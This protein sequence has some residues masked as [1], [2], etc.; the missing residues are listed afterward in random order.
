MSYLGIS[1]MDRVEGL[2]NL[3]GMLSPSEWIAMI[4]TPAGWSKPYLEA[5][6]DFDLPKSPSRFMVYLLDDKDRPEDIERRLASCRRE[7]MSFVPVL[8][9]DSLYRREREFS[10]ES[11]PPQPYNSR[12]IRY[13][14]HTARN[15]VRQWNWISKEIADMNDGRLPLLMKDRSGTPI[16][17]VV[18][19]DT[20]FGD[21]RGNDNIPEFSQKVTRL[22]R[23]FFPYHEI[24]LEKITLTEFPKKK[25]HIKNFGEAIGFREEG[26]SDP[27]DIYAHHLGMRLGWQLIFNQGQARKEDYKNNLIKHLKE[28][29]YH[30]KVY[31]D[32]KGMDAKKYRRPDSFQI[33]P[34][35]DHLPA[36]I[37][38][39]FQSYSGDDYH[40]LL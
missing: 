35:E 1:F 22:S 12:S 30:G 27:E 2:E 5:V 3:A 26:F 31:K 14:P 13:L 36:R 39:H 20:V 21:Y 24:D 18:R 33:L 19:P 17:R 6:R 40:R 29:G 16:L 9:K 10:D 23:T 11:H 15:K 7:G 4:R 37:A 25:K 38:V 8:D 32:L 28:K 34:P